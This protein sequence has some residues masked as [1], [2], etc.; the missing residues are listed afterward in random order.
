MRSPR[1]ELGE[2]R[3]VTVEP[4][5]CASCLTFLL[6][7]FFFHMQVPMLTP[8]PPPTWHTTHN[9]THKQNRVSPHNS[10]AWARSRCCPIYPRQ[11][12][13]YKVVRRR[14]SFQFSPRRLFGR[15]PHH[16][17]QSHRPLL[18]ALS[19]YANESNPPPSALPDACLVLGTTPPVPS[20][21][22]SRGSSSVELSSARSMN[23]K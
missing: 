22:L 10:W 4:R 13:S 19:V 2:T 9:T 17:H 18:G 21:S 6:F 16:T 12:S 23:A 15:R 5:V 7:L 1:R 11:D 8:N 3:T 14:K 20:P